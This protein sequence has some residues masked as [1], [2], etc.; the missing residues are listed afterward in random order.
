MSDFHQDLLLVKGDGALPYGS[1][2]L[3]L[4]NITL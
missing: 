2:A 4:K 3:T 1:D